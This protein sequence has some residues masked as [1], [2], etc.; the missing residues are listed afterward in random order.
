MKL[1][2]KDKLMSAAGLG[3]GSAAGSFVK[4]KVLATQSANVQNGAVA[5]AG[6][7][8]AGQSGIIKSVGDGMIANG[9]GSL[10][11]DIAGIGSTDVFLGGDETMAADADSPLMGTAFG[12][13]SNYAS[14][15]YDTTSGAAGEMNY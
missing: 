15:S 14:D 11:S 7:V 12:T 13:G 1:F 2:S 9:L 5:L 4:G 8:I 10:I 6:F 3:I